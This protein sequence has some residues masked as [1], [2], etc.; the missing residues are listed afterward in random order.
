MAKDNNS[1]PEAQTTEIVKAEPRELLHI[2]PEINA[3]I[4]DRADAGLIFD[5]LENMPNANFVA[6][7]G[8]YKKLE[9]NTTYNFIVEG[10]TT[11]DD[12]INPDKG[13]GKVDV[14]MFV[15]RNADGKPTNYITAEKVFVTAIK[16]LEEAQTTFPVAVR[17]TT[18]KVEKAA[19]SA[20]KYLR[21]E[22]ARLQ[23]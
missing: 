7:T 4:A 20:N 12:T 15:G 8:E 2:A 22:V 17:V 19:N 13:D 3:A 21:L 18:G 6:I 23:F 9:E 14:V 16:R 11:M 10:T 5:S 1:A